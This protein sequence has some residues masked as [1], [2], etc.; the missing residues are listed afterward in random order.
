MA[1]KNTGFFLDEE[2]LGWLQQAAKEN[3]RSASGHL[4]F[5][6]TQARK[7]HEAQK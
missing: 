2:N 1:K 6:L 5:L 3:Q 7:S 4:N